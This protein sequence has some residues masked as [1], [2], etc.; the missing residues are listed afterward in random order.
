MT[1]GA[2]VA[3]EWAQGDTFWTKLAEPSLDGVEGSAMAPLGLVVQ[4]MTLQ[5]FG[6]WAGEKSEHKQRN[7][8]F[9]LKAMK[10]LRCS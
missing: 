5:T 2:L 9:L 7:F 4:N 8:A 3:L 6:G 1:S 10:A